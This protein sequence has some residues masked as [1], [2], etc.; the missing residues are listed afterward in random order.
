VNL[1]ILEIEINFFFQKTHFGAKP[2]QNMT[3]ME[4][5]PTVSTVKADTQ[6]KQN[7]KSYTS[8]YLINFCEFLKNTPREEK[9]F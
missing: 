2:A 4:I 7:L 8:R 1:A 5:K 3:A 6:I 9:C